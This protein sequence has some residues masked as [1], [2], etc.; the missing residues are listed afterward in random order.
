MSKQLQNKSDIFMD[1]ESLYLCNENGMLLP[2]SPVIINCNLFSFCIER[3]RTSKTLTLEY[4]L[5]CTCVC[6]TLKT[7]VIQTT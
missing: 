2:K 1:C 7:D 4:V 5:L 3:Q 6:I